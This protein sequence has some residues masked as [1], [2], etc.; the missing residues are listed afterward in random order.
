VR[1]RRRTDFSGWGRAVA[2][3]A[4]CFVIGTSCS[5]PLL[6]I[7]LDS[8][9]ARP[10]HSIRLA[11]EIAL[12]VRVQDQ[13]GVFAVSAMLSNPSTESATLS[14]GACS[15]RLRGYASPALTEPAFWDDQPAVA[16]LCADVG[17]VY[18]V[19]PGS[20]EIELGTVGKSR[21]AMGVPKGPGHFGVVV[22]LNDSFQVLPGGDF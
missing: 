4:F 8:P 16:I 15:F 18:P 19:P 17:L 9:L 13:G 11:E 21:L 3:I 22:V 14:T 10:S 7:P 20:S 6:P 12:R 1:R 2:W 5:D